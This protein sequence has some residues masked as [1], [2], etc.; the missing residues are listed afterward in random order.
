MLDFP[1]KILIV[2]Y[3]LAAGAAIAVHGALG[4]VAAGLIFWLG[5]AVAVVA[6]A[7][8]PGLNRI[9]MRPEDEDP[10]AEDRALEA[11]MR[12]WEADRLSDSAAAPERERAA[13]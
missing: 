5:G 12:R 6:L 11:Q 4:P 8:V 3:G 1:V 2:G 13:R 10:G 9:F 7:V